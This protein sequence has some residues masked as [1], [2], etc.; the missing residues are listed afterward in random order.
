[1]RGSIE[2]LKDHSCNCAGNRERHGA[3]KAQVRWQ[4]QYGAGAD[5]PEQESGNKSDPDDIREPRGA[6]VLQSKEAGRHRKTCAKNDGKT[7]SATECET[8]ND[9]A[10]RAGREE[11]VVCLERHAKD[12]QHRQSEGKCTTSGE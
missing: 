9:S 6:D 4:H 5:A 1:M 10:Q 8:A 3:A 7:P 11:V 2:K 12:D